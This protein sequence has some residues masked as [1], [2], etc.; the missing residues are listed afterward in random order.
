MRKSFFLNVVP[1]TTIL[2]FS[3]WA[4]SAFKL[5]NAITRHRIELLGHF[6]KKKK[7]LPLPSLLDIIDILKST[8]P[9]LYMFSQIASYILFIQFELGTRYF[10]TKE[11][12][13]KGSTYFWKKT[14]KQFVGWHNHFERKGVSG[15]K[16]QY[17][18]LCRK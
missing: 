11:V 6:K 2:I 9:T 1:K 16:N 8:F 4:S 17:N 12:F 18:L 5:P 14:G 15:D 13:Q 10:I 3:K 7:C